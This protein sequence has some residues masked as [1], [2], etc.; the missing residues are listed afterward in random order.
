M[1]L[2]AAQHFDTVGKL[3]RNVQF[4]DYLDGKKIYPVGL[5]IS[6]V[7]T[8][9]ADCPFCFYTHGK[10]GPAKHRKVWIERIPL[11]QCL[12]QAALL[13]IKSITWTGG[14]EPSLHFKFELM[15]ERAHDLGLAQGILTNALELP[16]YKPEFLEWARITVTNKSFHRGALERIRDKVKTVGFVFNYTGVR[17]IERIWETLHLAE[18]LQADYVQVRPALGYLGATVDILPP[19]IEHPLLYMPREKFQEASRKHGYTQCEGFHFQPFI[20]ETG[21]VDVCP[22]MSKWENY[23]LGNIYKESLADILDRLPDSVPVSEFCQVCCR[24]HETNKALHR[25]RTLENVRFP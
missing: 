14:G 23:H 19:R 13:G 10:D 20:W 18:D 25:A 9:N 12:A 8:C 16:L 17:D 4:A 22:Y 11:L 24:H 5:E 2:L 21:S 15:V 3:A 7:G 1:N 6:P